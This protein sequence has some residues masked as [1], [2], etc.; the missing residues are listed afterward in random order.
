LIPDPGFLWP[1]LEKKFTAEKNYFLIKNNN[2][3]IPNFL[4]GFPSYR[5]SLQPSK[6][7]IKHE[8]F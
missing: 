4:K 8:I 2:L 6:E 3:P 7:S 5:R 1:K